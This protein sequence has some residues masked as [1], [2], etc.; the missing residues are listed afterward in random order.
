M[1]NHFDIYEFFS[2]EKN[3]SVRLC[4]A[5]KNE[6]ILNLIDLIYLDKK[7]FLKIPNIGKQTWKFLND[8]LQEKFGANL[9]TDYGYRLREIV[10]G[11]NLE[12]L[13]LPLY[14]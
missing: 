2:G 11:K 5:L 13:I 7:R 1:L 4:N 8:K 14:H 12:N 10:L 9:E 3:L 6:D